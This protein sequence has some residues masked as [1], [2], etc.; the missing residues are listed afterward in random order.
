MGVRWCVDV[1]EGFVRQVN[2]GRKKNKR[3]KENY[4][5]NGSNNTS[6]KVSFCV[7]KNNYT[8]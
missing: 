8:A 3:R 7:K 6:L 5:I 2:D 1:C 4:S